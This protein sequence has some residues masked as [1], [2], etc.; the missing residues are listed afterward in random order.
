MPDSTH[1]PTEGKRVSRRTRIVL[2]VLGVLAAIPAIAI[3]ILLTFD[4]NRAKPWLNARVSEAIE[5]PFA[6]NGDLTVDWEQPARAMAKSE[7]TWRDYIPWP[8]LY[9]NDVHVGNPAGMA[10]R[11]M[12]SVRQFSFSLNPF[13][14]LGHTISIPVLRFDGP[15]VALQRTDPAHYNWVYKRNEDKPTRWKLDLERVVLA[16]GVLS[17]DDSVTRTHVTA[18]I[19][20]L[21]N[22]P[23]YGIGWTLKGSYN[24][25]PVGGG[26]KAGAV[27]SLKNQGTP[28]PI[29][30]DMHS[31]Q[32]RIVV[33]GTVTRPARLAA[34][35]LRL[36][37][38]APSMARLY[39]FTGL[40]L[41]ET[42]AFT[43]EG[44]LIGS[45]DEH[46]SRWTYDNFKGKV[47]SS[48]IA[49]KLEY[50]SGK[51]RGKLTG[52][53]VSHQLLFTDLGPLIGADSNESKVARGVEAV[54]PAG[55][56]LPVEKFRTERWKSIDADVRFAADRIVR[57]KELP[58]TKLSTH[59]VMKDGVL[60]LNPLDFGLAGGTLKSN[61]RLDG[62]DSGKGIKA[63]AK[64]AARQIQ[65]KQLFP[66]IEKV[67]QTT[68][69][70]INGDANLSAV[71]DSVA[72]LLAHSNGELKT[73]VNQGAV[74]K[75]LLEEM[76]LNV[77]NIIVTKLFGDRQVKLNCMATDFNVTNG[78]AR[79]EM[80]VVDTE[81]ALVNV[82]GA[83][84][85]STEQMDLTLRPQTKGLRLFSLRSPIYVRGTFKKPDVEVDKGVLAM[86]AGGA[87]VL[88]V[89][90][91]PVAA[92]LPL[93]H[94]GPGEDSD[95]A[96][97]LAQAR[98]KPKAPPPGQTRR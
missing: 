60:T 18:D 28:F 34:L 21:D 39:N 55:K 85:L 80:F 4:W 15:Q 88:A 92:M 33:E 81:E 37:L 36:K 56:A 1:P 93:I 73:L 7:R 26:G 79:T 82:S 20:T 86:K 19:D 23:A 38:A 16:K 84:N 59:L 42:P 29:Q 68:V 13:A 31:G 45:I 83:I 9:A 63:T 96:R 75:L 40:T 62:S 3:V 70:Q 98:E 25:A 43:T 76:G 46:S 50:Q 17:L 35:D 51:P 61:I 53:V 32:T 49:G 5:R 30:A 87:A 57:K 97:L 71:G 58:I 78:V 48:D 74:S 77:G 67:Q 10:V 12:A 22:N 95:C 47:G 6:I 41:P 24:G 72:S 52:N 54:Q 27:L 66:A 91:A 94:A 64:V 8:H 11:D 89:A 44:R 69:G 65:I 90:A 14:L 2:S